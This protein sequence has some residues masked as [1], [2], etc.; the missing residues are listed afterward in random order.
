MITLR[1]TINELFPAYLDFWKRICNM[2]TPSYDKEALIKQADVIEAF[3]HELGFTVDRRQYE[4]AGD[5]LLIT[6]N[7]EPGIAP[8]VLLAHMD[9][10]HAAGAFG[11]PPVREENGILYGPGVFDCKGGIVACLLAM[12][13]LAK[14]GVPHRTIK[15]ILNSDEENGSF[16][17]KDGVEFIRRESRGA[18][19]AFNAEAGRDDSL[20]VGRK[21]IVC[22]KIQIN[23]IAGHAGNAYFSSA[24]A[25]R[26]AAYKI[27][28][29]ESQS[30]GDL[31]FNC[32]IIH[33][34]KARNIVPESCEI[35]VD[36]RFKNEDQQHKALEILEKAVQTNHVDGCRAMW[37]MVSLR[38]AMTCTDENIELFEKVMEAADELD[39]PRLLPKE[40]GGGS[41]SA[42][43]V[44]IGIPTVCSMG[45]VG[46]YEHTVRE[47]ADISTLPERAMLLA[48]SI[49]KV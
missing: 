9:T 20:T 7:G 21:G 23:G 32:G 43:T 39:L 17:G 36:I 49:L 15:L 31:T 19:A 46:R 29:L 16:I 34:G 3:C 27:I 18:C 40:R 4:K 5:T 12:D 48:A 13:A 41:D 37:N 47:E 33:G 8:V 35:T 25:I 30:N 2:E 28:D 1:D 26:E 10:V 14:I 44:G 6:L 24:S 38:P 11:D 42:Y 45:P 22:A